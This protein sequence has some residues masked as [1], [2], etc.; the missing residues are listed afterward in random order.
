MA[1]VPLPTEEQEKDEII[2]K[3]PSAP[4]EATLLIITFVAL[5]VGIY[6]NWEALGRMYFDPQMYEREETAED[7]YQNWKQTSRFHAGEDRFVDY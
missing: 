1:K 5:I 7:V 6:L 3:K 2:E 4:V